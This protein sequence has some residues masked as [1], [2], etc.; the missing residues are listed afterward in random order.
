MTIFYNIE[1]TGTHS[2]PPLKLKVNDPTKGVR[3]AHTHRLTLLPI[4]KGRRIKIRVCIAAQ[5]GR[6]RYD[7]ASA[8]GHTVPLCTPH[9]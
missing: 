4:G 1:R 6:L 5:Y 9:S 8:A 3:W 2:P 7:Q